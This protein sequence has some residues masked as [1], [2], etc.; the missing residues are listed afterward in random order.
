MNF[1][2]QIKRINQKNIKIKNPLELLI[3][4]GK[5]MDEMN[6]LFSLEYLKNHYQ[7]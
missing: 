2:N 3:R 5:G 7:K 1:I 6:I 4:S